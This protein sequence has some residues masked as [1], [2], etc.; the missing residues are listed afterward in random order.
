MSTQGDGLGFPSSREGDPLCRGETLELLSGRVM[1]L[2]LSSVQY[3]VC[4]R[5]KAHR[6]QPLPHSGWGPSCDWE[7]LLVATAPSWFQPL[8]AQGCHLGC[9]HQTYSLRSRDVGYCVDGPWWRSGQLRASQ[10]PQVVRTRAGQIRGA[11]WRVGFQDSL[12][13]LFPSFHPQLLELRLVQSRSSIHL[14]WMDWS[15]NI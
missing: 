3:W 10:G 1:D 6:T 13:A 14:C 9:C 4:V 5:G 12:M 8:S 7:T 11:A 2:S 15:N